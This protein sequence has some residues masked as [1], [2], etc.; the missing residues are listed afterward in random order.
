MQ[1]RDAVPGPLRAAWQFYKDGLD[2]IYLTDKRMYYTQNMA[3]E[4]M[5]A[6]GGP[7][8]AQTQ[9]KI[10]REARTLAGDMAKVPA[11][12]AMRELERA[13]PYLTQ[14][15]LGA[16]HLMRHMGSKETAAMVIPRVM[17]MSNL[18]AASFFM[19]TYWNK[20][21]REEFWDRTPEY[22]R[23]KFLYVPTLKLATA[24]AQGQTL[25]YS[26]DLYYRVPIPPDIAPIVAGMTAWWQMMGAI[27]ADATPK[28][29]S[30]DLGKV[31]SD[32][33]TPAM[34]PSSASDTWC[35]WSTSRPTVERDTRW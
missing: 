17:I 22:Q 20:E 21:S 25:P 10:I 16:Y 34:P 12:A 13:F 4:K 31:L 2:A 23:W 5:R 3:I 8:S 35:E 32:S 30:E 26:R 28:P 19:M 6:K 9:E 14:T 18:A 27:P 33:L 15:K 1:V 24:F 11:S 29:I 7:V